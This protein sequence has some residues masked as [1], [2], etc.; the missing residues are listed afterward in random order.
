MRTRSTAAWIHGGVDGQ[1]FFS[2]E[3]PI[4]I[5]IWHNKNGVRV[6]TTNCQI[7]AANSCIY[8]PFSAF[9]VCTILNATRRI[10]QL[11]SNRKLELWFLIQKDFCARNCIS[12]HSVDGLMLTP[13][14]YWWHATSAKIQFIFIAVQSRPRRIS[15]E[16]NGWGIFT[17]GVARM[18]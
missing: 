1:K 17:Y 16:T 7:C 3:N 8:F 15:N 4:I 11:L 18:L 10:V 14:N 5:H 9:A 12:M 2:I 13:A 6:S